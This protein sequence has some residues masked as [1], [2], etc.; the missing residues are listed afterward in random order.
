MGP[1]TDIHR[2]VIDGL[3]V[4]R[5]PVCD[6][7]LS[8]FYLYTGRAIERPTVYPQKADVI[9]VTRSCSRCCL[10][11]SCGEIYDGGRFDAVE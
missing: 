9:A 11:E 7:P 5:C 8:V 3:E 1:V 10:A 6:H 4:F 2:D